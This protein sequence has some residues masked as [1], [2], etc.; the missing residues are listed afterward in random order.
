MVS[1]HAFG[2][3]FTSQ[4]LSDACKLQC[5]T[6]TVTSIVTL[7]RVSSFVL[8]EHDQ[9]VHTFPTSFPF[10]SSDPPLANPHTSQLFLIVG[11][12]LAPMSWMIDRFGICWRRSLL[13]SDSPRLH[14]NIFWLRLE[15]TWPVRYLVDGKK[16]DCHPNRCTF[17]LGYGVEGSI[18]TRNGRGKCD[19][20]PPKP[21]CGREKQRCSPDPPPL[22]LKEAKGQRP[23]RRSIQAGGSIQAHHLVT[24]HM[25][26]SSHPKLARAGEFG[27]RRNCSSDAGARMQVKKSGSSL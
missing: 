3:Q 2:P 17:P 22:I 8:A 19:P 6:P 9:A 27:Q 20:C 23:G 14:P 12:L 18:H 24:R 15:T 16:A 21:I 10:P 7:T 26:F 5:S 11:Y 4:D 1:I 13:S 25:P